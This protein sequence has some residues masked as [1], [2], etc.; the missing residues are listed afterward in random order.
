MS[1]LARGARSLL[2]NPL[3]VT[4]TLGMS[5]LYFVVTG[6]QFWVT[7]YM[8]V[9]LKFNKMAVVVLSTLCFLTAPTTG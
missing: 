4:I 5:M 2:R 1:R 9:V 8:V 7:E 6:I 3:Y